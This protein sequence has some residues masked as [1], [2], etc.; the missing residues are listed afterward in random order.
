MDRRSLC[1]VI[2][3]AAT[4]ILGG[5]VAKSEF[6]QKTA[7]NEALNRRLEASAAENNALHQ[8]LGRLAAEKEALNAEKKRLTAEGPGPPGATDGQVGG[9]GESRSVLQ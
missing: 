6:L 5:C 9:N 7:E 2:V 3:L 1:P 4:L 8:Q